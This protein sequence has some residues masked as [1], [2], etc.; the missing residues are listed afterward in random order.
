[1]DAVHFRHWKWGPDPQRC[2]LP[3][4]ENISKDFIPTLTVMCLIIQEPLFP[5][6]HGMVHVL[7]SEGML[8]ISTSTETT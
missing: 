1:M 8:E 4:D 2:N 5:C 6:C 7:L 3:V